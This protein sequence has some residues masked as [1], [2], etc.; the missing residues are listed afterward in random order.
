[1]T[2]SAPAIPGRPSPHP[3]ATQ[4]LAP[5]RQPARAPAACATSVRA[6]RLLSRE[7]ARRAVRALYIELALYPKP[8]L[9]S[10]IDTGSHA[11]MDATTFLRSLFSLRHYFAHICEAGYHDAPFAELKRLGIAAEKRMLA[12]TR[13]INTHRGAIFCVGLLCAAM[14]RLRAQNMTLTPAALRT[15]LLLRWSEELAAHT[16]ASGSSHGLQAAAQ[17]A[18]SGAREEGALGLPS[19]FEIGLPAL[20]R[21]LERGA[22]MLHARIDALFAL[23]GHISDTNVYHRGGADGARIVRDSA[24]R[25]MERGGTQHPQWREAALDCHLTFVDRRLSPGGAADLLAATCF[26]HSLVTLPP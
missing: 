8:G 25:F 4:G 6:A 5:G 10:F 17:H 14:G 7:V 21:T 16:Q 20:Q 22:P 26:V 1:M 24:Q 12:A 9:V 3:S 18:A 11:D 23:M 2:T 19:V 15:A 13:G